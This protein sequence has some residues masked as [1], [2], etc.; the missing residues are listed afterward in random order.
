MGF[1]SYEH[2]QL[3]ERAPRCG[4]G[5]CPWGQQKCWIV[6]VTSGVLVDR[7]TRLLGLSVMS[8]LVLGLL[9]DDHGIHAVGPIHYSECAIPLTY[10]SV[11]GLASLAGHLRRL[12]IGVRGFAS[13][14]VAVLVI[15]LGTFNVWNGLALRAHAGIQQRVYG[16][17]E[18]A[19][20]GSAI[21]LADQFG[22]TWNQIPEFS[23]LGS[24]VFE[25]RPPRPDFS[26]EVLIF[27][28]VRGARRAVAR[29]FPKRSVYRLNAYAS[30][31]FLRL[32]K[33]E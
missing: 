30:E 10:I 25:W 21:V 24:W 27:H 28:D 31:P 29:R 23:H 9:H 13:A 5:V 4:G 16:F 1:L 22:L 7:F 18:S 8:V 17:V 3:Y 15:E 2:R 32:S 26:D 14:I 19:N 11:A 6:L 12:G 20:L 33:L